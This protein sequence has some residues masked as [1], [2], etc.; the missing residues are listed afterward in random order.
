MS[1][2][3]TSDAEGQQRSSLYVPPPP[4]VIQRF[5]D[6]YAEYL[7]EMFGAGTIIIFGAGAQLQTQLWGTGDVLTCAF[8]E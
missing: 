2:E 6:A 7:A 1:S 8:G 4:N 5:R 3:R